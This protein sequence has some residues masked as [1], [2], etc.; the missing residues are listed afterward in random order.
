MIEEY[1]EKI[2]E[3]WKEKGRLEGKL[4]FKENMEDMVKKML[5]HSSMSLEDC[6]KIFRI[7][8]LEERIYE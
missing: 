5:L 7:L 8:T 4:R 6:E 3:L 1:L 2:D